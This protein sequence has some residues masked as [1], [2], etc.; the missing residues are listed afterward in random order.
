MCWQL[1]PW[2]ERTREVAEKLV[3]GK[4]EDETR[5]NRVTQTHRWVYLAGHDL[6]Q[7]LRQ[8]SPLQTDNDQILTLETC[9]PIQI[10]T[11]RQGNYHKNHC[12][13]TIIDS[14]CIFRACNDVSC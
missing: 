2:R 14:G 12:S 9:S 7:T 8:W 11:A 3:D 5:W 4:V 6:W 13:A 10:W 1:A